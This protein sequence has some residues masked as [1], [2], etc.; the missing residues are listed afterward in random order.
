M[1]KHV[2]KETKTGLLFKALKSIYATK[3]KRFL[4][5]SLLLHLVLF[6]MLLVSWQ[7]SD[8]VKVKVMPNSV[9]ARVI[10]LDELKSLRS[11]RES[12]QR[13]IEDKQKLL[14]KQKTR[15][16]ELKKKKELKRKHDLK[17][18]ETVA[19]KKKEAKRKVVEQKKILI[20][21]KEK[22]KKERLKKEKQQEEVKLK[23][24]VRL[25][26]EKKKEALVKREAREQRLLDKML[27]AEAALEQKL[28][29]ERVAQALSKQQALDLAQEL[30]ETERFLSL[31]QSRVVNQWHIPPK[32]AGL[33]VVLQI[34]L[35]PTGE[36]SSV[37]VIEKSGVNAFDQSAENAAR[38]VR[39]YPVPENRELFE[40]QFR[41]FS[42]RFA[43]S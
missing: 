31:I 20:Q 36:L 7:S 17:K 39:K 26:G 9:Q 30:S 12:E 2:T 4:I 19:K 38:G 41:V 8:P 40:K 35:L 3:D 22:E 29:D 11:K 24:R 13:K 37:R 18:K 34:R 32:S 15:K 14:E 33:S 43:P 25:E 28:E 6:S 27:Q 10:S 21:K 1:K 16:K 42:M 5:A 23:E